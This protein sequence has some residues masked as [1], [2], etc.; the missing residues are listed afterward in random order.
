MQINSVKFVPKHGYVLTGS[1]DKVETEML[2]FTCYTSIFE[3]H[4]CA[5]LELLTRL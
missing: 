3:D 2:N 4:L 5:N 1:A